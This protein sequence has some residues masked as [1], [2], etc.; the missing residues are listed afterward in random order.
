MRSVAFG[1]QV[2]APQVQANAALGLPLRWLE[3]GDIEQP[4]H[5]TPSPPPLA[6]AA[7]P[8]VARRS[9]LAAALTVFLTLGHA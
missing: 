5:P 1:Q 6:A 8:L 2:V 9:P 4:R 7:L 3:R